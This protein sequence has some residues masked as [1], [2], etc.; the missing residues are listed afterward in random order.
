MR[1]TLDIIIA[2][3]ENQPCTEKELRLAL[4]ALSSMEFILKKDLMDLLEALNKEEH[5]S[6]RTSL[7]FLFAKQALD[8]MWEAAKIDPEQWLGS[9]NI[10]G[11]PEYEDRMRMNK[12]IF[13]KATGVDL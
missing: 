8:R 7:R 12:K 6:D 11:T 3:K 2:V 9:G 4:L 1:S 5:L 13:K 10:P